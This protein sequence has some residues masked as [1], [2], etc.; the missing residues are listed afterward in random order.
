VAQARFLAEGLQ[1]DAARMRA[2]LEATHGMI[3]GEAV[4]MRLAPI[5]GRGEAHHKVNDACDAVRAEGITLAA[6]LSRIP[7]IAARL[8]TAAV[9]AMTDPSSYLG[10]AGDFTDRVVARARAVL[11]A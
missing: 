11:E 1:V 2:N 4:M 5:L 9:E 3:M 7:A 6:A 8:D 10:S